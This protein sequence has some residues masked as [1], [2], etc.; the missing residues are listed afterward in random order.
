V[1]AYFHF[2]SVG[3]SRDICNE[4]LNSSTVDGKHV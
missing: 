3:H 1:S 4:L 2:S